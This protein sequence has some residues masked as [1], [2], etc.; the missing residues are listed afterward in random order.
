[1]KKT[2]KVIFL[3]KN[4]WGEKY[5]IKELRRGFVAY[6]L[7]KKEIL[8]ANEKNL[9]WLEEKK[10]KKVQED[11]ILKEKA[12]KIYNKINNA[13]LFF[14]LKKNE[15]GEPFGS[16]GFKEILTEL[17]K[18]DFHCQISQLLDFHPL[19]KL[20]ENIIKIKLNNN[21]TAKLKIIIK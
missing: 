20:G 1:M 6:L 13:S 19:N 8:L 7:D 4:Q 10:A 11:L 3:D 12:Q 18:M 9:N 16:I 14:S 5:E 17:E 2:E 15:K 21:L